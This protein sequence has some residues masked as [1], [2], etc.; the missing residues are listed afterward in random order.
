LLDRDACPVHALS[1]LRLRRWELELTLRHLKVTLQMD[2]SSCK[3]PQNIEREIRP[4]LLM[5]ILAR[6]RLPV[7]MAQTQ[8]K[9]LGDVS[10]RSEAEPRENRMDDPF[11]GP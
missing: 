4:H 9:R 10:S 2:H 8:R 11:S 6:R 5:H 1:E 3:T 7:A